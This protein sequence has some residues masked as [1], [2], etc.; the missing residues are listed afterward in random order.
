MTGRPGKWPGN[1][2]PSAGTVSRPTHS[3]AWLELDDLV[4]E[5]ERWPVRDDRLD[6][7]PPEGDG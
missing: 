4:H 1:H 2:Q 7:L 3:P 5:E 6:R